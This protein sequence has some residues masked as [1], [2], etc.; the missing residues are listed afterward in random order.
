MYNC[1]KF[2]GC[3][4][5]YTTLHTLAS[6]NVMPKDLISGYLFTRLYNIQNIS[7]N[8]YMC[9]KKLS[10]F[11]S[12]LNIGIMLLLK[13]TPLYHFWWTILYM[14]QMNTKKFEFITFIRLFIQSSKVI[15][16]KILYSLLEAYHVLDF[17]WCP[18]MI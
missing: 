4:Y 11:I 13:D 12:L 9:D 5:I 2:I 1:I 10:T 7:R 16:Q 14:F 3:I 6:M 17:V 8:E 18:W 15:Y